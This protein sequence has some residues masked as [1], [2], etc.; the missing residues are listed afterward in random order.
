VN[1]VLKSFSQVKGYISDDPEWP[2]L[3]PY[4]VRVAFAWIRDLPR[5]HLAPPPTRAPAGAGSAAR[6]AARV[7][8]LRHGQPRKSRWD[9]VAPQVSQE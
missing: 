9:L 8:G 5:E 7:R 6:R 2:F 3:C 4:P 1:A